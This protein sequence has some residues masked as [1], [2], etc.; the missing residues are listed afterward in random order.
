MQIKIE[1]PTFEI[2]EAIREKITKKLTSLSRLIKK[3]EEKGEVVLFIEIK[4]TTK[5]HKHGNVFQTKIKLNLK[6]KEFVINEK[7]EEF[8]KTLDI[9]K[10]RLKENI[11]KYK[12]KN[13]SLRKEINK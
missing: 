10:D 9:A 12:E 7:G 4:K 11:I 8:F 3:I 1:S 5:H 2:T 6:G 13:I